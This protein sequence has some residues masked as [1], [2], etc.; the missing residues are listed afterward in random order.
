MTP[1]EA[2]QLC[3]EAHSGQF[4]R[5]TLLTY[6]EVQKRFNVEAVFNEYDEILDDGNKLTWDD[7]N[8]EWQLRLPYSSHPIAVADMLETDEEKILAYLHDVIEDTD[9]TL[10]VTNTGFASIVFNHKIHEIGH[11]YYCQLKALTKASKQPYAEYI[12]N[13]AGSAIATRKVKL[14]DIFHNMSS[15][16]TD[17]R[18]AKYFKALPILLRSI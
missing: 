6:I 14:A 7:L 9:A 5:P 13:I 2:K 10:H 16:P 1:A 18:K 11:Y 15:N 8:E 17:K 12:T 3:I 4:R